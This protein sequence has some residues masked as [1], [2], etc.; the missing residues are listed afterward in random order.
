MVAADGN[1]MRKT[2]QEAYDLIK[3][4]THHHFQWDAEVY[5]DTTSVM[6][7]HYSK[8]AF[9]LS[10]Q[11]EVLENDIGYTIQ[12]VQYLPRPGHPNTFHYSYTDESDEDEPSEVLQVQ[13]YNNPLSGSPTPSPDPVVESLSPSLTP[14]GDND[15]LLEETDAFL[16]LDDSIPTVRV[17]ISI[18]T[19]IIWN[20]RRR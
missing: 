7:D 4:M 14:Y 10:E 13:K 15:L 19:K 5:H 1:F 8:T 6:S 18:T 2:P 16:S 20:R 11:V 3:N 17:I 9:T 12:S